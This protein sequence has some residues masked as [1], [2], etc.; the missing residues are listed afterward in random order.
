MEGSAV[1]LL[2]AVLHL[3]VLGKLTTP[4]TVIF[5][6]SVIPTLG[7]LFYLKEMNMFILGTIEVF[8]LNPYFRSYFTN[9]L[10]VVV[11]FHFV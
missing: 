9:N 5:H 7:L 1:L 6:S 3:F 8:S 2:A 10:L 4:S 11:N